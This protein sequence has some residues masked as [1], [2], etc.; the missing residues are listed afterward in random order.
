MDKFKYQYRVFGVAELSKKI[1]FTFE[2]PGGPTGKG[3]TVS[4]C[5]WEFNEVFTL[6]EYSEDYNE[7]RAM[8]KSPHEDYLIANANRD[9]GV[10]FINRY[11]PGTPDDK[12]IKD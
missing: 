4:T 6:D 9:L 7:I 11:V 8:V 1:D 3:E 12:P 10:Q 2:I 5:L